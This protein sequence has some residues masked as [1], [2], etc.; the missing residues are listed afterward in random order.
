MKG[1]ILIVEDEEHIAEVVQDNLRDEG[2]ETAWAADGEDGLELARGGSWDLVLLDVRLP[3][4]DGFEVCRRLRARGDTTPVLFLTALRDPDSRV[5]GLEIGGDDYLPKPF[6]LAELLARVRG[7]LR[8]RAWY[9][10]QPLDPRPRVG[11]AEVDLGAREVRRAGEV[12]RLSEKEAMILRL[13]LERRGETVTRDQI[14]DTVWGYDAYP[15]PRTI[16]NFIVR[17]RKAV[18]PDPE[19]PRHLLTVRGAGYVLQTEESE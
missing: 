19:D 3:G 2:F 10:R 5:R 9:A 13:L 17:L 18:E 16:D 15:T 12:T 8:R 14:L 1:R 4:I 11:E 6:H 7:M